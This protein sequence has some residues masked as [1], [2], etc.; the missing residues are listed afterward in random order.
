MFETIDDIYNHL[1]L[2]MFEHLPEKWEKAYL[3]VNLHQVNVSVSID[4]KYIYNGKI[5]D[6]DLDV[7]DGI[8]KNSMCNKAFY[9][10][11]TIMQKDK[12]DVPW[13]KARFEMT[14]EG[15]FSIDFK[16]DEDFAWYKSLDIDSQKY[17]E[18]DIN[19]I[20]KIKSW[21]G[22]PKGYPRY[23]TKR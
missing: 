16:Y 19:V 1:G 17:D 18:L 7:I 10:L 4:S 12:N 13:N 22:L 9:A 11:Y 15:D 3:E 20:N 14:S 2:S 21:D 23:W 6:F 8:Y 5:F